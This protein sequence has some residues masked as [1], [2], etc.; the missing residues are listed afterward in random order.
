MYIL[1]LNVSKFRSALYTVVKQTNHYL[2]PLSWQKELERIL[3]F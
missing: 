2:L 3:K 1:Q